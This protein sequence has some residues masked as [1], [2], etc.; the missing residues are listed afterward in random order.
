MKMNK[1]TFLKSC[2]AG[3]A[4]LAGTLIG[5][6]RILRAETLNLKLGM[7]TWVGYLPVY[8]ALAKDLYKQEGLDLQLITFQGND[9]AAAFAAG[10][11][12]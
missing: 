12:I 10:K 8:V 7:G 1:R 3:A 6:P 2:A 9:A 11:L 5:A 4:G